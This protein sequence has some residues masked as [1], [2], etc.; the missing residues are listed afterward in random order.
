MTNIRTID[1][2]REPRISMDLGLL[3]WGVDTKSERFLQEAR[4]RDISL[5][6]ALISGID[7]D[8]RSGDVIGILYAGRKARYRVIWVRYD[9]CGDKMQV[10]VHRVD[11]DICP[12]QHLLAPA[13]APATSTP[14]LSAPAP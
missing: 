13:E 12:W 2:R 11:P 5:S 3:V 10:A 8:L 14:P 1:R 7:A 6:G 9:E 4:A